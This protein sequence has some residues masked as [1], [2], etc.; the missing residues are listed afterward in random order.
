MSNLSAVNPNEGIVH[1]NEA[2]TRRRRGRRPPEA[3]G[4]RIFMAIVFVCI[5]A[6]VIWD[7]RRLAISG[8]SDLTGLACVT[9]W[10]LTIVG[11]FGIGPIRMLWES[12]RR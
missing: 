3:S 8:G 2:S 9:V 10:T 6:V 4:Y 11:A 7:D 1:S 12:L 5:C